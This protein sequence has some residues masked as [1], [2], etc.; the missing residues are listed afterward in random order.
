[1]LATTPVFHPSW[2]QA[3]FLGLLQG[4]TE[5]FPISSLGHTVLVPALFGWHS[6]VNSQSSESGFLAFVVGLHCGTAIALLIYYRAMWMRI[7]PAFFR[8][9]PKRS[10]ETKDEKLAWLIVAATI[11]AGI[12]GLLFEHTL[13][14]TFAKPTAAASFLFVNGII[15]AV[16]EQV[17]RR[18]AVAVPDGADGADGADGSEAPTE[19]PGSLRGAEGELTTGKLGIVD[20]VVIGVAQIGA[21]FAGISR[22]GITMVAGLARG[23]DHEDAARFTFLLATPIILAAGVYKI[24]DLTGPLGKGIRGQALGGAVVAGIAAYFSVAFLE[25]YFTSRNL[26]P[27]AIYCLVMGAGCLIRFGLL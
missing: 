10:I 13:R 9:I 21:L 8:T 15:L 20:A 14:T 4:V 5:L 17:R 7:I 26:N 23:L 18:T 16:G 22:S 3:I 2:F 12:I 27:F 25:R 24:G 19:S 11:P 1:V 6:I